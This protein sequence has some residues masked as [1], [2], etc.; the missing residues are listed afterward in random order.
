MEASVDCDVMEGL[1]EEYAKD[2]EIA[3]REA[4]SCIGDYGS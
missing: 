4:G 3:G 2:L 1:P